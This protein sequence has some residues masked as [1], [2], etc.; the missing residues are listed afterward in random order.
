MAMAGIPVIVAGAT[1]YR[2]R[3]FT[4]DPTSMPAYLAALEARLAEPLGRRLGPEVVDLAWQYAY[5]F[6]FEYPFS[7]PWHLVGFW[8]DMAA[9]PFEAVLA[10]GA[11]EKYAGTLRALAGEH[12]DWRGKVGGDG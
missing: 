2:A 3:G 8:D 9:R 5:R 11:W 12:V 10:P 6:F 7:S 1:H 4:D